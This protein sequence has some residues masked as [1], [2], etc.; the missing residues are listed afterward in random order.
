MDE[1]PEV[2]D[3]PLTD[4]SLQPSNT[5]GLEVKNLSFSFEDNGPPILKNV[6]FQLS[7][8]HSLGIFGTT[9]SG[10]SVLAQLLAGVEKAPRDTVF[11]NGHSI[12]TW[13]LQSYRKMLSYVP[14]SS[15]LFSESIV[16]NIAF[17]DVEGAVLRDQR[18]QDMAHLACVDKDINIFPQGYQTLVGEKGV[19]LS[20]GQRNRI[21]L[22]RALFKP[23]AFLILDDILSAVDH[24]TEKELIERLYGHNT[25]ATKVI[26]SHRVSALMRCEH[27]LVIE[28][29]KV[30]AQG[31]HET[32]IAQP[33]VYRDT[34]RYQK[35][36]QESYG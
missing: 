23:Y 36:D 25:E 14:Q 22:A 32:L 28:H 15:F 11:V 12:E 20:G 3:S 24:K 13:P 8:G 10:K 2:Q 33:G 26:V 34:W 4:Y 5:V 16:D 9:G 30:A 21:A 7:P 31:T 18:S 29:G 19:I 27:I 6:S 17:A 35:M 1:S